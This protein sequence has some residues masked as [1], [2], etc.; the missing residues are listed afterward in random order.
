MREHVITQ[1]EIEALN[2][3][4]ENAHPKE[5]LRWATEYY[6][7][8]LATVTSFQPTG[9][10]TLHLLEELGVQANII[11]LDTGLLFEETYQLIDDVENRFNHTIY[12]VRPDLSLEQQIQV[13]GENLWES[14][15]DLCCHIRKTLPLQNELKNY[16]AWITGLRRDQSESRGKTQIVSWD[17][18][19]NMIKI[20]PFATWTEDMIW[21]YIQAYELP[22]NTLHDQGYTSIGCVPCTRPALTEDDLRSGRWIN[23]TK[24]ECG[25]HVDLIGG[26]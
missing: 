7:D 16:A 15:P 8:E 5:I 12:R 19:N 10:V 24:I 1:E 14:N 20:C 2:Q 25:I 6:K 4:F 21:T 3:R 9:I 22:Y 17:K 13:H 23:H 26:K 11:T 18:R